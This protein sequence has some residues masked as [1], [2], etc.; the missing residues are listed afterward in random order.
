[1]AGGDVLLARGEAALERGDW[2]AARQVFAD[3]L[4]RSDTPDAHYGMARALEWAGDFEGAIRCYE[5]A[6]RGCRA[7]G[8]ARLAALI[9]GRELSFLHAA[10][11][12]NGAAAEGWLARARSLVG[13][14]DCVERG[15]V[16]LAAAAGTDVAHEVAAAAEEA[17][18]VARRWD[19]PDLHFCALAYRG[20]GLVLRG[21]VPEGMRCVDEAA[22]AAGNGEVRD[23]LVIGEIYCKM[24][25]CC[26]LALDV[27]RAQQWLAVAD[28][29]GRASND[30]WVSA[31]C[32]M[33]HGGVLIAAGRWAEAEAELTTALGLY[34]R[35]M[36]ALR[37]G[38]ALRLADLR[39]RQ[40]R[41]EEAAGLLAGSEFD[42]AAVL[43]L[44]RLH[45][46]RGEP[47]SAAAVLRR[48]LAGAT[49]L[50]APAIA[51]LAQLQADAGRIHD[52]ER[53]HGR[54]RGLAAASGLLHAQALAELVAGVLARTTGGAPALPPLEA[55]L[56]GFSR[57][58]LPWEAAGAR[59]AVA[60]ELRDEAPDLARA[61]G[62]TALRTFQEL[63]AARSADEA[64]ALLRSLGARP[65]PSP[66]SGGELTT[67]ERDVLRLVAEGLSNAEIARR[68][69]LSKRTVEHHVGAILAKS[70][71]GTRAELLAR[72]VRHG[73]AGL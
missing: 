33:H 59:L 65:G 19:D 69:F 38:A 67:R 10:V 30:L 36:R 63:G 72:I 62:R 53:L 73:S 4:G 26:E 70:G 46:L 43:P 34:D 14:D 71:A 40:G 13:S 23:H 17:A 9:A 24:L 2:S 29:A 50:H 21:Q 48:C 6:F 12:G 41:L 7:Q 51:L 58:G 25:L 16:A 5:Q 45:L 57:A 37:A 31:I 54:L 64:A 3:A 35:G 55:A 47:E 39:V 27:H 66:R 61:E 20:A 42:G 49:V 22:V 44:A 60:R 11:R 56:V 8:R 52:A 28:A 18:G 1:M 15:W 68:L 32:L